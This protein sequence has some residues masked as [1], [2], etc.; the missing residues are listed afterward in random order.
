MIDPPSIQ[1]IN[2][3]RHQRPRKGD[4]HVRD[5]AVDS[6]RW[7]VTLSGDQRGTA[8]VNRAEMSGEA[9]IDESY[10]FASIPR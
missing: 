4:V 2:S 3:V 6:W 8:A 1:K 10:R 9:R 7:D 5:V